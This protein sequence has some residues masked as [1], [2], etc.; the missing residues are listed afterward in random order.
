MRRDSGMKSLRASETTGD[1]I[2][3]GIAVPEMAGRHGQLAPAG[4]PAMKPI[5]KKRPLPISARHLNSRMRRP[6]EKA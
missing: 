3:S 6:E 1:M 2:E 5:R 4:H